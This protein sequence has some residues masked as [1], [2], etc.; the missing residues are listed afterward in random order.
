MPSGSISPRE[1]MSLA[2]STRTEAPPPIH[3]NSTTRQ[4]TTPKMLKGLCKTDAIP[5][6]SLV[7]M[8][9]TGRYWVALFAF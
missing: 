5:E 3:S 8:E 1:A 4:A 6:N 2:R 9:A 7:G